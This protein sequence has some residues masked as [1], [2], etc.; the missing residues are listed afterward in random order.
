MNFIDEIEMHY[1]IETYYN[2]VNIIRVFDDKLN[3]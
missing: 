2:L 3:T 1:R